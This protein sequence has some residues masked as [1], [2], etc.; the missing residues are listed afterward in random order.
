MMSNVD[1]NRFTEKKVKKKSGEV[2][3]QISTL[4]APMGGAGVENKPKNEVLR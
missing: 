2:E 1:R 3:S 4:F